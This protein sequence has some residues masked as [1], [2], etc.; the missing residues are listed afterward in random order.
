[1]TSLN[2]EGLV[3]IEQ[4]FLRVPIEGLKKSIRTSQKYIEKEI[5]SFPDQLADLLQQEPHTRIESLAQ[6]KKK[7]ET[8]KRKVR[9][10]YVHLL[11]LCSWQCLKNKRQ[12]T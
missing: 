4:P 11:M 6:I 8:L 2:F 1:M 5:A 10:H 9:M 7:M 3:V 12:A